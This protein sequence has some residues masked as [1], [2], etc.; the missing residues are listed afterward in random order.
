LLY[1]GWYAQRRPAEIAAL[2]AQTCRA[3]LQLLRSGGQPRR[4][5]M[6]ALAMPPPSHMV[7]NP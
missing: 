7:C 6:V 1:L 2:I 4:S 5:M 3:R